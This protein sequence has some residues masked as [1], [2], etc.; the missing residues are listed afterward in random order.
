MATSKRGARGKRGI[1]GPRGRTGKPGAKGVGQ[2]GPKGTRGV[3][4]TA[5]KKGTKGA[6]GQVGSHGPAGTLAGS[7]HEEILIIKRRIED[8]YEGLTD[9][10]QR[11]AEMQVELDTL[12]KRLQAVIRGQK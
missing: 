1:E 10:T 9:Q 7:E 8:L 6:R 12:S 2:R 11:T 4:G 5:G 3:K